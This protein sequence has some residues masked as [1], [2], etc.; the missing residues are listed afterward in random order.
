MVERPPGAHVCADWRTNEN[1][2]GHRRRDR[3]VP[4]DH[5][6]G[7]APPDPA[8]EQIA[9]FVN[10]V[11]PGASDESTPVCYTFTVLDADGSH[12]IYLPSAGE[13]PRWSPDARSIL[14]EQNG[15]IF[16]TPVTGG[17][18]TNLTNN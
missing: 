9:L 4:R 16:V 14:G 18:G 2:S 11:C 3:R 15:D 5:L 12:P 7:Q 8:A 1:S 13:R 10:L 6:R 17:A